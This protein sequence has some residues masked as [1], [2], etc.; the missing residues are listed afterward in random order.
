[1]GDFIPRYCSDVSLPQ[2]KIS[3]KENSLPLYQDWGND[4]LLL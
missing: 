1:M 4:R 2:M 3:K